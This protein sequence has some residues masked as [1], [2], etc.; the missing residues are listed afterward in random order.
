M[1]C[2]EP[3]Q[4]G[5]RGGGVSREG[6]SLPPPT[7]YA[8]QYLHFSLNVLLAKKKLCC[9]IQISVKKVRS[10]PHQIVLDPQHDDKHT[11][12]VHVQ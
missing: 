5:Y 1:F 10:D 3:P 8:G 7:L 2:R 4:C 6:Q 9:R 12:N 11:I